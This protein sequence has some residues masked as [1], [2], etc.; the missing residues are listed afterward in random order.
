MPLVAVYKFR[1]NFRA[2]DPQ[3]PD[4]SLDGLLLLRQ[5]TD[6]RDDAAAIAA[7]TALD[8]FDA[9]IERYAPV[10]VAALSRPQNADFVEMHAKALR[11]GSALA[12]YRQAPPAT[13]DASSAPA[14]FAPDDAPR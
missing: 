8:A 1:A 14:G 4:Q 12:Y 9:V 13:A 6:T 7:C 3:R 2:M 5:D 10:D 11:E